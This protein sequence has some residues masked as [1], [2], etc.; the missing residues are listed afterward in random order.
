MTTTMNPTRTGKRG[1][2]NRNGG[3]EAPGM[4]MGA[5]R[6]RPRVRGSARAAEAESDSREQHY[7]LL[8]AALLGVAIGA[9]T[10]LLLRRGPGGRRPIG[11]A[12]RAARSGA[13]LAGRGARY[14]WDR[15]VDLW[16][17]VPRE[18]IEGQVREYFDSARDTIDRYVESE[19]KDLRKAIRRRRKKLGF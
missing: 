4:P 6:N 13:R 3:S 11:P 8:T 17:R 1:G 19:L 10:T 9:G 14:A 5:R 7:D 16:E 18:E 15:G 2:S 12:W